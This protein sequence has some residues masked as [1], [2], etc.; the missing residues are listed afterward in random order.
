MSD[1]GK[2]AVLDFQTRKAFPVLV[3]SCRAWLRL[4]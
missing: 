3:V 4:K 1:P 2:A